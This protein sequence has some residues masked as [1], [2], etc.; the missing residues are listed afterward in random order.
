MTTIKMRLTTDEHGRVTI[1]YEGEAG[2]AV[3]RTFIAP[4]D[5]GYVRELRPD[6]STTQPCERLAR[7][8]NTLMVDRRENLP[9]LIRRE[10]RAMRRTERA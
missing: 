3:E 5:G 9:A 1:R 6:G 10:Y 4:M 2:G 8:G 7:L